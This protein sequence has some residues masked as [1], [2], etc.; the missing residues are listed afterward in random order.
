[1]LWLSSSQLLSNSRLIF[2]SSASS[3]DANKLIPLP[4]QFILCHD[5]MIFFFIYLCGYPRTEKFHMGATWN[6]VM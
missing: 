2:S 5:F 1:M 4:Q 6:D 3:S